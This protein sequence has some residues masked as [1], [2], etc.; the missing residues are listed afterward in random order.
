MK[1]KNMNGALI[2]SIL[3]HMFLSFKV[4]VSLL[5]RRCLL[6][7]VLSLSSVLTAHSAAGEQILVR[8][9]DDP[10]TQR[11]LSML[12]QT[13]NPQTQG[14][15][16]NQEMLL[17]QLIHLSLIRQELKRRK[18]HLEPL[19]V[20]A[21][22]LQRESLLSALFIQKL[23][24]EMMPS[25]SELRE[26]FQEQQL[27]RMPAKEYRLGYLLVEKKDLADE[28]IGRLDKNADFQ[29]MASEFSI[30]PSKTYGGDLGWVNA[31]QIDAGLVGE[32]EELSV[33]EH[34]S[35]PIQSERGWQILKMLAKRR[36]PKP[37]FAQVRQELAERLVA[38]RLEHYLS[39]LKGNATIHFPERGQ[40]GFAGKE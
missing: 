34:S 35:T 12:H 17:D 19:V 37:K 3:G 5:F 4:F 25:E 24:Q 23:M 38:Q 20:E 8:V 28:L 13:L 2:T 1:N 36:T 7:G 22:E 29:R 40:P 21:V 31:F 11:D 26:A 9:N 16:L 32:L 6:I 18:F 33:D 14:Q 10:I 30:D 39:E 27:M 15:Q